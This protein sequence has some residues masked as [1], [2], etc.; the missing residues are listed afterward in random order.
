MFLVVGLGNP[1]SRYRGHRHN[2]GFMA[3]D[4]WATGH[5]ADPAKKGFKGLHSRVQLGDQDVRILLPQTF[6]NLSGESVQEAM[7]FFKI[8]L[9]HVIVVHDELDLPFETIR[10]KRGGGT[11]G[12]NGLESVVRHCGGPGFLRLRIGIGRPPPRMPTERWVLGDFSKEEGTRLG[13]VLQGASAALDDLIERG[14]E[15]AMNAHNRSADE[16]RPSAS[17]SQ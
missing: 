9:D 1:G 10:I 6:M 7:Q 2:V 15:A 8:S 16:K 13:D 14:P 3:V 12:H 4:Q 17:K 11:A 5:G